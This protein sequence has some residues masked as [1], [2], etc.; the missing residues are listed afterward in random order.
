MGMSCYG[1]VVTWEGGARFKASLWVNNPSVTVSVVCP[2]EKR[3]QNAWFNTG[4]PGEEGAL[5]KQSL[6]VAVVIETRCGV[7]IIQK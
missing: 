6:D 1:K 5:Q 3:S 7:A 4:A 2:G